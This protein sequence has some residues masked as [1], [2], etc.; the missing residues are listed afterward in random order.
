MNFHGFSIQSVKDKI[1]SHVASEAE[2]W[3]GSAMTYTLFQSVQ[4]HLDDLIK[5]Q[6]TSPGDLIEKA[7]KLTISDDTLQVPNCYNK[8]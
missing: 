5:T 8:N 6:P 3:L 2:Q 7:D 1:V 4:E